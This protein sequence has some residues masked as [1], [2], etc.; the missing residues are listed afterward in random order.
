MSTSPPPRRDPA[1]RA[2]RRRVASTVLRCVVAV[3]LM[4]VAYYT[5]P[6]DRELDVLIVLGFTVAM[7]AFV[8]ALVWEVRAVLH[9][10]TPRL[11]A[12][13]T[14]AVGLPLL[15]LL[16][17]ATYVLIGDARPDSFSEPLSRTDALYFTVTVF[18]TVGF[19]DI[20]PRSELA[21]IVTTVQMIVGL[22]VVG[23]VAKVVLEAV[24]VAERRRDDPGP[25]RSTGS[26]PSAAAVPDP[27]AG[28]DPTGML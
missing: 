18:A 1:A 25:Q 13:R 12:A 4:L 10:D 26:G 27:D 21:R 22:T 8:V 28:E 23:V 19:G 11:R 15:L 3:A 14:I 5:A 20:V 2:R 16:F 7:V 17:A 9:S 6:L 24:Q